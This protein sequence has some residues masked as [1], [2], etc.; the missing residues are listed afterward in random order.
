MWCDIATMQ[1]RNTQHVWIL[2][3]WC[4]RVSLLMTCRHLRQW[5]AENI[6]F[7]EYH[8]TLTFKMGKTRKRSKF[9]KFFS[10]LRNK[11]EEMLD[12]VRSTSLSSPMKESDKE[13]TSTDHETLVRTRWYHDDGCFMCHVQAHV[14]TLFQWD[15][16][17]NDHC[18]G[19]CP[20]N[21][22]CS[23]SISFENWINFENFINEI[24]RYPIFKWVAE[25]WLK[26]R[27]PGPVSI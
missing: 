7:Y 8:L 24:D 20:D 19:Y 15:M 10:C 11:S 3:H 6:G 5:N 1:Q 25:F 22:S 26:D 4:L 16:L 13:P 17:H 21:L 9:F 2:S 14:S 27:A 12:E 23:L 18:G